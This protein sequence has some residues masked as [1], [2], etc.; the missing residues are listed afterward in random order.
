MNASPRLLEVEK[1]RGAVQTGKGK[2][3]IKSWRK[4]KQNGKVGARERKK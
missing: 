2:S 1:N 4:E 3:K